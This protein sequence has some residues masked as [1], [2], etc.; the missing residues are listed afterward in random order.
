MVE[1]KLVSK[2]YGVA[3]T[4]YLLAF[5]QDVSCGERCRER[6]ARVGLAV[7]RPRSRR[8]AARRLW[9]QGMCTGMGQGDEA[10]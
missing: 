8:A 6:C 2:I 7:R 4:Y 9:R 1:T 5:Q 3:A 10:R